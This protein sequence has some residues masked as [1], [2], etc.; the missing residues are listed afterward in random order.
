M[1]FGKLCGTV[2]LLGAAALLISACQKKEE[3]GPAE[4][5]GKSIDNAVNSVNEQAKAAADKAQ[6]QIKD[7]G[8]DAGKKIDGAVE[9]A[10]A[11]AKELMQKA[12]ETLESTGKK[13]QDAGKGSDK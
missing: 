10:K 5:V 12:G 2:V 13:I 7:T 6:D 8:S 11:G 3:P 4:A 9:D 1:K